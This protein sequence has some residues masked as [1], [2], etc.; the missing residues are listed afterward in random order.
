VTSR[1][2]LARRRSQRAV[3][4]NQSMPCCCAA[5]AARCHLIRLGL[6][7]PVYGSA[8]VLTGAV[9]AFGR[10]VGVRRPPP[11]TRHHCRDAQAALP[12]ETFMSLGSLLGRDGVSSSSSSC[13][14]HGGAANARG[15][16]LVRP[17]RLG[18]LLRVCVIEFASP[19]A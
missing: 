8:L 13:R 16:A 7:E 6:A 12:G 4:W 19:S 9:F 17:A 2:G 15:R 10:T 1:A 18:D 3:R 14:R 5:P 11:P